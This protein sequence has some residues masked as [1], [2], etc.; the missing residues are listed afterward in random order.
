MSA[1]CGLETC[2]WLD[3]RERWRR[4]DK[5]QVLRPWGEGD[6]EDD[7]DGRQLRPCSGREG[8]TGGPGMIVVTAD[9]EQ[10]IAGV[11]TGMDAQQAS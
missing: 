8:M 11:A 6:L 5:L 2:S 10:V 9:E 3:D 1:V 7:S 4:G